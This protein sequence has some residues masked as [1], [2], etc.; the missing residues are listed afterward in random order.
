MHTGQVAP[1]AL[2]I[3]SLL[4]FHNWSVLCVSLCPCIDKSVGLSLASSFNWLTQQ[5]S[6]DQPKDV[7]LSVS[8]TIAFKVSTFMGISF[9][10]GLAHPPPTF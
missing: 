9:M 10:V 1:E 8:S 4:P 2:E 7:L 6:C 5:T 3:T